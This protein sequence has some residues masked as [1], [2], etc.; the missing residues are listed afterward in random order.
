MRLLIIV[1]LAGGA[2]ACTDTESATNLR[3]SGPPMIEQV[4][5]GETYTASDGSKNERR[6]IAFGSHPQAMGA[7]EEHS[8]TSA[9][10]VQH[11]TGFPL[12]T[13]TGGGAFSGI[14]VIFG[15]LLIGNY[16]EQVLCN[17]QVGADSYDNVPL[18]TTPDDM[19][20]C[21]VP[22][23][24]AVLALSCTGDHA[25]CLCHLDSG[26]M[27]PN[28]GLV[29]KG[30]PVGVHDT[31][32]PGGAQ[33]GAAD[34][35]RLIAGA[36][37]IKCTDGTRNINVPIDQVDSY[38]DPSGFQQV[39]AAG[40][41][42]AMGPAVVLLP[43]GADG[44]G[45]VPSKFGPAMPTNMTCGLFFSPDVVGKNNIQVCAPPNGRPA[46]M[47]PDGCDNVNLDQC[48][49]T[50]TPGDTS[51]VSWKTQP[52][53]LSVATSAGIPL[54][55]NATM[56]DRV[57]DFIVTVDNRIPLDPN[58][59]SNIQM[60]QNGA[61]Y[62][63]FTVS[64]DQN[65]PVTNSVVDIHLTDATVCPAGTPAGQG[66]LAPNAMYTLTFPTSFT[67]GYGQGPPMPI[68]FHFTTSP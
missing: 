17:A 14:R 9:L 43:A 39:P 8:T 41:F 21:A 50:C 25:V 11:A 23:D 2:I 32:G 51:A 52:L 64:L 26:C 31:P 4:L 27:V 40:G 30:K 7:D 3:T 22:Q 5:L 15:S 65:P 49:E 48:N 36:A 62:T 28:F 12:R 24:P 13:S 63:K 10:A 67:D 6:I 29:E 58:N 54:Q 68:T 55:D 56:F 59:I 61:P 47:A 16:L 37:G 38:Y 33:D 60:T 34:T 57:D 44:T 46:G 20:K 45:M 18:G 53:G 42:D 19:A 35:H 66:C 1:S